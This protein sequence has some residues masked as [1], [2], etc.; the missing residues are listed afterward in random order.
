MS[1]ILF[2]S[3]PVVP[4]WNDSSKNLVRDLA[5]GLTRHRAHVMTQEGAAVP[6]GSSVLE[7]IYSGGGSFAPSLAQNARVLS[8]LFVGSKQPIWHFFFAPN[9][10]TS[11]VARVVST[12]RGIQTV[13][14]VCSAPKPGADLSS[15]LF[16]KVTVVLS[17]HTQ[18]RFAEDKSL[19]TQLVRI[20]PAV[21]FLNEP[22][23]DVR[24]ETRRA[25]GLP[26]DVPLILYPGDAEFGGGAERVLASFADMQAGAG[27]HLAIACRAKTASAEAAIEAL[28]REVL[29]LGLAERVSFLGET[30]RI[31]DLLGAVDVVTLPAVDLYAKM[32]YPLVVLEAM[33]LGKAVVVATGTPAEELAEEGGLWAISPTREDL[34]EAF[35]KLTSDVAVREALGKRAQQYV[36]GTFSVQAMVEAY[37]R[38]YDAL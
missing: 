26:V 4:P 25:F 37:E 38:M 6:L 28:R 35:R 32:D 12:V 3:K 5:G 21:A 34:A 22:A 11:S 33:A 2:V 14:T 1:E 36:R 23:A 29:R 27:A 9:P 16:A 18:Q 17:R 10:R 30:P 20:P 8:R 7:P 15:I 13:Q 19:R 31:L 24:A